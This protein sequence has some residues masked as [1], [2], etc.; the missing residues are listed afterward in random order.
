MMYCQVNLCNHPDSHLTNGHLCK[1]CLNFGHGISECNNPD[2]INILK[3][4][5][6]NFT[7]PS[8]YY[9][10]IPLCKHIDNHIY[11]GHKCRICK[12]F[13]HSYLE[14]KHNNKI[15]DNF[16]KN[17]NSAIIFARKIMDLTDGKIFI[18]CPIEMGHMFYC[19]RDSI[20]KPIKLFFMHSDNWG[21][22]GSDTDDRSKL[23]EFIDGYSE[24]IIH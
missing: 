9:C 20:D 6:L 12:N 15:K 7:I 13:G 11:T 4:K 16:I 3:Q 10:N 22:Y 2:K 24:I 14:C 8:K 1:K 5:S 23:N 17:Q 21:Q 19:K 18:I